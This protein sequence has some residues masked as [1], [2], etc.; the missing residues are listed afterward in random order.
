MGVVQRLGGLE[1]QPS[2]GADVVAARGSR[3]RLRLGLPRRIPASSPGRACPSGPRAASPLTPRPGRRSSP[4]A[5]RRRRGSSDRGQ[6][7]AG[8]VQAVELPQLGDHLG[9]GSPVDELHGVVVHAPL[10]AD[11]V[12]RHDVRVVQAGG[13]L[14][15]DLEPLQ[16]PRVHRR[17]ERQD[18]Q[19]H[20]AAERELLGLVDDPHAAPADLAEDPE[21][22]QDPRQG[23]LGR[24]AGDSQIADVGGPQGHQG[25]E[26]LADQWGQPGVA[27][28]V[29][30]DVGL[31]PPIEAFGELVGGV[32]SSSSTVTSWEP[33]TSLMARS[34][35][36]RGPPG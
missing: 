6:S 16:L 12:D 23:R 3:A 20:A 15:L 4:L 10:A 27:A 29:L 21:V 9:Q 2:R 36:P 8:W 14:G 17:G 13:G 26:D 11:G 35:S 34:R 22:A 1:A 33:S 32:A 7:A 30:L 5:E 18:L 19:R 28:G 25:R 31:L 24:P